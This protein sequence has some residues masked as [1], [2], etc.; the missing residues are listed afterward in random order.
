VTLIALDDGAK[1]SACSASSRTT[2]TPTAMH[3]RR[4]RR[5]RL[6]PTAGGSG[7]ETLM[8]Q[9]LIAAGRLLPLAAAPWPRRP[10]HDRPSGSPSVAAKKE[11][12]AKVLQLQQPGIERWRAAWS[13]SPPCR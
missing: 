5:R 13:S 9:V 8:N 12:V 3:P 4:R 1:L 6:T 11:L 7:Q 10:P 2:P